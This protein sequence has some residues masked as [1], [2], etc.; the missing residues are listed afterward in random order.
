MCL[1]V[2]NSTPKII[3]SQKYLCINLKVK[4]TS[5]LKKESNIGSLGILKIFMLYVA[6]E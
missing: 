4:K 1:S 3:S 5:V 6:R 2:R